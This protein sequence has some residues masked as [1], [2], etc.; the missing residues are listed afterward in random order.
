MTLF[1]GKIDGNMTS[2]LERKERSRRTRQS[3]SRAHSWSV[4]C[5][6]PPTYSFRRGGL[7]CACV[8][9]CAVRVCALK[10][11]CPRLCPQQVR[12]HYLLFSLLLLLLLLLEAQINA[13][14]L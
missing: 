5:A 13:L 10:M 6:I 12:Q 11:N 2:C 9:A 4:P 8:R 3:C 7:A 1:V 14:N